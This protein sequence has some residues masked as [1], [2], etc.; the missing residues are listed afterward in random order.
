V[1]Q[2]VAAGYFHP[3][4]FTTT[5]QTKTLFSGGTIALHWD[6]YAAW[7]GLVET[8]AAHIDIDGLVPPNYDSGSKRVLQRGVASLSTAAL[9]KAGKSRIKELLAI[10]NELAAPFGSVEYLL[11]GYGIGNVDYTLKGSDPILTQ[12]GKAETPLTLKYFAQSPPVLYQPGQPDMA[13]KQYAYQKRAVPLMAYDPTVGLF[14][15][16]NASNGAQLGTAL[17]NAETDILQGHKPL[18][19]WDETVKTW[20]E[21]GG[22]AIRK[23]YEQ[24]YAA[25]H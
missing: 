17:H 14:S 15:N 22:D 19:H 7:S 2:L 6:N 9:K 11:F 8:A 24:S 12:T 16:T 13:K 20:K 21:K 18:S 3:D 1:R 25:V 4:T 23:E 10:A 5:I